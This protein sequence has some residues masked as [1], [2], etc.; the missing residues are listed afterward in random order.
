MYI[1][2]NKYSLLLRLQLLRIL[3]FLKDEDCILQGVE[4]R[5]VIAVGADGI[6]HAFTIKSGSGPT[7]KIRHT[8]IYII[9]SQVQSSPSLR[10]SFVTHH[11]KRKPKYPLPFNVV[12]RYHLAH[13]IDLVRTGLS[14]AQPSSSLAISS[15]APSKQSADTGSPEQKAAVWIGSLQVRGHWFWLLRFYYLNG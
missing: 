2:Q 5:E 15:L 12:P 1:I 4:S 7:L 8:A 13:W 3:S 10:L 9:S 6:Q 14:S 11:N